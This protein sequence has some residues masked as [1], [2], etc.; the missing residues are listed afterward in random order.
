MQC[1]FMS[2]I[3]FALSDDIE[4][5]DSYEREVLGQMLP[6]LKGVTG[7]IDNILIKII[8]PFI[9]TLTTLE[10]VMVE[11]GCTTINNIVIVDNNGLFIYADLRYLGTFHDITCLKETMNLELPKTFTHTDGHFEMVLGD[12]GYVDADRYILRHMGR[13]ESLPCWM[14]LLFN[15][16]NKSHARY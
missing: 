8:H 12:V 15:A 5:L 13:E 16:F 1:L 2:C 10:G 9:T 7:D 11:R 4:W 14:S 6:C 3:S